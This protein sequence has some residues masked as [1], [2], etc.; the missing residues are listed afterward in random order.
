MNKLIISLCRFWPL[1]RF[2]MKNE[3]EEKKKNLCQM[4]SSM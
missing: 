4:N 3:R 1:S 2:E